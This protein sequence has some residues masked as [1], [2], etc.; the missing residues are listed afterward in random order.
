[1]SSYK[2]IS[3]VSRFLRQILWAGFEG[4]AAITQHV[5]SLDA[6]VLL[7]PADAARDANRRLSLWLSQIW[8]TELMRIRPVSRVALNGVL[9]QYPPF[10][11]NLTYLITPSTNS[12]EGDQM[13]LGRSL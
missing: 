8:E 7:N 5:P 10:S 11:V 13:V 3:E 9:V 1:M 2:V 12:V 4:D 6:I